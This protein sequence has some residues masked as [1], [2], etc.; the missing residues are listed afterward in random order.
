MGQP[1]ILGS[2]LAYTGLLFAIAYWAERRT[3]PPGAARYDFLVYGLSLTVYCTSW[4]FYGA[5]G[6][7]QTRGWDYLPIY[8]GPILAFSVGAP[9]V[10]RLVEAGKGRNTTSIADFLSSHFGKS[11]A[12]AAL[13]T[14]IALAGTTPYIALQLNSVASTWAYLSGAA[15]PTVGAPARLVAVA[16]ALAAFAILFGTRHADLTRHNRGM[17]AAIAL[18]AAVKLAALAAVGTFAFL[19]LRAGASTSGGAGTPTPAI[20]G[21]PTL[22]RFVTLTV[23]SFAAVLCLPRQFHVTVVECQHQKSLRPAALLFIAYLAAISALVI[24]ITYAGA[25]HE[26]LSAVPA[27]LFVLGL[28]IANDAAGLALFVFVGGFAAATGMVIVA[29]VALSTMVAN[30]LV[31]PFLLAR[32]DRGR[33]S[34]GNQLLAVRR[35]TIVVVLMGAA[36]FAAVAPDGDGLASLGVLAFAAAAQFAP[37]LIAALYWPGGRRVGVLWGMAAG[38]VAW[39]GCLVAPA[40]LGSAPAPFAAALALL[41]PAGLDPLTEGV[42]VSLTLNVGLF[43]VLSV[44]EG[45]GE[46]AGDSARPDVRNDAVARGPVGALRSGDLYRLVEQCIGRRGGAAA[47]AAFEANRGRSADPNRPADADL[48][49]FVDEQISRAVGATSAD[50]LL[51]RLTAGGALHLD[52]VATL[53]GETSDKV[54]FSQELVRTAMENISHGVSVVDADLNLVAWNHVYAEMYRYPPDMVQEGRPIADLIRY[55]AARGECGPGDVEDHVRRRVAHLRRGVRHTFESTRPD[56]SVVKIE[57]A[58][59]QSGAYVTTF[60]DVT[61][62]KR[63]QKALSESERSIRFYTDNIPSMVAFADA[64]ERLLFANSAYRDAFG[65]SEDAIGKLSLRDAM[66]AENYA[67]RRPHI[68]QALRGERASFDITMDVH[69]RASC[70]QVAYVPQLRADGAVAGFFGLYQDVTARRDAEEALART[71]ETLEE[72]VAERTRELSKLNAAL[73]GARLEAERATAS[74]TRFL[75]AASHDVLQPLNAARLFASALRDGPSSADDVADITAKIDASIA[76]ADRLLRALLNIS[77][78]DAGGV[79][80]EYSNFLLSEVFDELQNEFALAAEEKGLSLHAVPT[81]LA[82]RSDRGL[83][84]SAMQNFVANAIRYTDRG[85]IV[86]CARRD[87]DG[88]RVEVRDSGRGIPADCRTVI[89]REFQRLDRDLNVE[90]AGLGL[91]TVDRIAKLLDLTVGVRSEVGRGSVFSLRARRA[92]A[93]PRAAPARGGR[94]AGL[95]AISVLCIDNDPAVLDA[96]TAVLTRWGASVATF[97][98]D[99]NAVDA[100]DPS[101]EPPDLLLLDYQLGG[102]RTGFDALAALQAHWGRRPVTIMITASASGAAEARA[103]ALGVPVMRKPVEPAELRALI[104]QLLRGAAE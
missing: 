38:F 20:A 33:R 39:A 103:E 8:L 104:S 78:L 46:D 30:D 28:P 36:L 58:R 84:F 69:G 29:S 60:T 81:R 76:S 44:L 4:T 54:N 64:E 61:D 10:R 99:R 12:V 97:L 34:I 22:D 14:A 50:I 86:L 75:A 41:G 89:F 7:A 95:G 77:K 15:D 21:P 68:D 74:K 25:G 51:K 85:R 16:V 59:S 80:P 19:L 32:A 92:A 11:R 52:D 82:I 79:K 37:A 57:G 13:V 55:N 48:I 73:E 27:D 94:A 42:I 98:D 3:P 24:P 49:A 91:A 2:V 9:V 71:N 72:R 96:M 45:M 31:A 93:A 67:A 6:T 88:I 35:A 101:G 83:F 66:S 70:M 5:V 62:Y 65:V 23:L 18:D 102:G 56:G 43:V 90:G 53:L 40:F 26:A 87:G 100:L 17:I 63:I 47:V 1:I